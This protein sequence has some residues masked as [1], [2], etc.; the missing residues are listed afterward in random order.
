MLPHHEISSSS[1]ALMTWHPCDCLDRFLWCHNTPSMCP[2][3]FPTP[4][5]V[6]WVFLSS[7]Y[8]FH[9]TPWLVSLCWLCHTPAVKT[10]RNIQ[11]LVTYRNSTMLFTIYHHPYT[12]TMLDDHFKHNMTI[13]PPPTLASF[14]WL[15]VKSRIETKIILF[16][17]GYQITRL[18]LILKI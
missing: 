10:D 11:F 7:S 17:Y 13:S 6:P 15:P 14:Y 4:E 8:L 18:H 9:S 3:F 5:S 16:K 2:T 12:V 1:R